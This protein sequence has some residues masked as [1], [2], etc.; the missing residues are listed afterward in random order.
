MVSLYVGSPAAPAAAAPAST[1]PSPAPAPAA[2]AP[3]AA[4]SA[5]SS[6][7]AKKADAIARPHLPAAA[8]AASAGAARPPLAAINFPAGF[9]SSYLDDRDPTKYGG[10][11]K[12]Y[13][14]KSEQAIRNTVRMIRSGVE[15]QARLTDLF[16]KILQELCQAR[17]KIAQ[18][19]ATE[20]AHEFG[21]LRTALEPSRLFATGLHHPYKEYNKVF[22]AQLQKMMSAMRHDLQTFT[23]R[24][25]RNEERVLGRL[26]SFEVEVLD[27]PELAKRKW[28]EL[29]DSED[30]Q[31]ALKTDKSADEI[32]ND[33]DLMKSLKD[34][35]PELYKQATMSMCLTH[36]VTQYPAPKIIS[37]NGR[38]VYDLSSDRAND[39]LKSLYVLG[40]LRLEME[41]KLYAMSRYL[42][43][44][45]QDTETDPIDQMAVRS[46]ALIMHQDY[47]LIDPTLRE[48]S[49]MFEKAVLWN[50]RSDSLPELKNRVALFRFTY[51]HCMPSARGD[52]AIGDW[53]ELALYY[54]HGFHKTRFN[55]AKLPCFEPLASI[56]LSRY[57]ATYPQIITVE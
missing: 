30:L 19:S 31:R 13:L 56:T 36:L 55:S 18:E 51:A 44:M 10:Q 42:T 20:D 39:N 4:V 40:T 12:E 17:Q 35:H 46:T 8:A 29:V 16:F 27:G 52:G 11:Q 26:C 2:A 53:L 32:L 3:A 28:I 48:I 1:A 24:T 6:E 9:L 45:Y 43:W 49:K 14:A 47:F 37:S 57:L 23:D 25:R 5:A 21:S 41:G 54:F 22:M 38:P 50:P 15:S 34:K 33:R 7:A